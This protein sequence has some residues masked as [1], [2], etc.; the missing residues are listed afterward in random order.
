M[1]VVIPAPYQVRGDKVCKV[2]SEKRHEGNRF[3]RC[4]K[5][6]LPASAIFPCLQI[7]CLIVGWFVDREE[8]SDP[9]LKENIP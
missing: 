2:F 1:G 4:L 9:C 5:H 7:F 8:R 3:V 6:P